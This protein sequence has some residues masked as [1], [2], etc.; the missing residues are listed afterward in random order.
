MRSHQLD[1]RCR[2]HERLATLDDDEMTVGVDEARRSRVREKRGQVLPRRALQGH[3]RFRAARE[4]RRARGP[5][6]AREPRKDRERVFR[7]NAQRAFPIEEIAKRPAHDF[8][9][10]ERKDL[11]RRDVPGVAE[12]SPASGRVA[13]DEQDPQPLACDAKGARETDDARADDE[14]RRALH[15]GPRPRPACGAC[16]RKRRRPPRTRVASPSSPSR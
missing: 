13:I 3:D 15:G 9:G 14:D 10:G 11:L 12:R 5:G 4:R 1:F 7:T 8:G 6:E 16:G 2:G